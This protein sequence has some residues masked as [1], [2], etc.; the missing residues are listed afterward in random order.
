M[1]MHDD[2]LQKNGK[3][4]AS[5]A[6]LNIYHIYRGYLMNP[7]NINYTK[8]LMQ[9][10]SKPVTFLFQPKMTSGLFDFYVKLG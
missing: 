4:W 3:L 10:Q 2:T 8:K 9:Y 7:H 5:L 1:H 6:H